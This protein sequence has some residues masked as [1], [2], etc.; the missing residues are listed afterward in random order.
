MIGIA[1][2]GLDVARQ[3]IRVETAAN[4]TIRRA[5]ALADERRGTH[6]ARSSGSN[7]CR[8]A[9]SNRQAA[10]GRIAYQSEGAVERRLR[11]GGG[12]EFESGTKDALEVNQPNWI[13]ARGQV[14]RCQRIVRAA[15]VGEAEAV[16]SDV[17][18]ETIIRVHAKRPEPA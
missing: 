17:A 18:P 15:R 16:V 5:E 10:S 7:R 11:A 6:Q 1:L 3:V 13:G 8:K 2:A 14:E 9:R 12:E 4:L